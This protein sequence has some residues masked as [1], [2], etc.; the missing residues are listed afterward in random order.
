LAHDDNA[1]ALAVLVLCQPQTATA[2]LMIRRLA[3]ASEVDRTRLTGDTL[4]SNLPG[5]QFEIGLSFMQGMDERNMSR[6][7]HRV[8]IVSLRDWFSRLVPEVLHA[9]GMIE[10][11]VDGHR[12]SVP[13]RKNRRAAHSRRPWW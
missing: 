6:Q 11:A 8:Q 5:M 10:H 1:L 12:Q 3:V 2:Y 9:I 4:L 7:T 13:V